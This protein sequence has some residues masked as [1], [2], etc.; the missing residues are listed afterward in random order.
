M[1]IMRNLR[2]VTGMESLDVV[3]PRD[4]VDRPVFRGGYR[5]TTIVLS[6]VIVP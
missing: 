3:R 2:G 6:S 1:Q 4:R 5:S